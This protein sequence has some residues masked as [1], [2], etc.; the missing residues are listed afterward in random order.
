MQWPVIVV[1]GQELAPGFALAGVEVVGLE[2]PEDGEK[3]LESLLQQK[4]MALVLVAREIAEAADKLRE[5]LKESRMPV[6]VDLP[7]CGAGKEEEDELRAKEYVGDAVQ[8]A[9]GQTINLGI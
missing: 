7:I 4:R 1:C 8:R 5:Q 9:I 6:F 3:V 2:Q